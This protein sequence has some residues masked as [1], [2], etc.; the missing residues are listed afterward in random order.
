MCPSRLT[1]ICRS[2]S[3]RHFAPRFSLLAAQLSI[4]APAPM[5]LVTPTP[6]APF[7]LLFLA[8]CL[9]LAPPLG[10]RASAPSIRVGRFVA[11]ALLGAGTTVFRANGMLSAGLLLW[12]LLWDMPRG[13]SVRTVSIAPAAFGCR[14]SPPGR[15]L[16]RFL[17]MPLAFAPVVPFV[18]M[19]VWL[20]ARLCH[21]PEEGGVLSQMSSSLFAG[22]SEGAEWAAPEW[23]SGWR[24]AYGS[25]QARYW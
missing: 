16:P 9:L 14:V 4:L 15:Q 23:C 8:M 11:A 25:I 5:S 7:A 21:A 6:E 18:L 10:A 17:L 3:V 22:S 19:Q 2:L 12:S 1:L 24:G 13:W 20:H